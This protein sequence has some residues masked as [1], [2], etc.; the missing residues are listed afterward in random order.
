MTTFNPAVVDECVLAPCHGI[1]IQ[2]Y[3]SEIQDEPSTFDLSCHVYCRSSDT[4]LGLPFNIASYAILVY[5]VAKKCSNANKVF[6]PKDLVISTGDTHI[7]L[8]HVAQAWTQVGRA[9]LPAP[10]LI[11]HDSVRTKDWSGITAD[12]FELVGY[13]S[14]A[15]IKADMAV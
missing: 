7:Y 14:H 4:F 8:N 11:V 13:L 5:L 6:R 2:F 3:V 9:P 15:A 1:A 12:D 10:Q